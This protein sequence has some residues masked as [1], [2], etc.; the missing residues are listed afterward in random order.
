MDVVIFVASH[1]RSQDLA[2]IDEVFKL[3]GLFEVGYLVRVLHVRPQYFVAGST[4]LSEPVVISEHVLVILVEDHE[5]AK[6]VHIVI[7]RSKI[8]HDQLLLVILGVIQ[9]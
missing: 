5:L 4:R 8:L 3:L 9:Y 1:V 2:G 7:R 6:F